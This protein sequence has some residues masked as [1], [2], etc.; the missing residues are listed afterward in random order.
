LSPTAH[1]D[2]I[3]DNVKYPNVYVGDEVTNVTLQKLAESQMEIYDQNKP[4][5]NRCLLIIDDS[6]SELKR[7][8]LR[9]MF[10]KFTTM[11]RHW[12]GDIIWACHNLTFMENSQIGN[13]L[14]WCIWD[15]HKKSLKTLSQSLSTAR[16][17]EPSLQ[18]FI[19]EN[20]RNPYSFVFIDYSKPPDK[21]FYIGFDEVYE[22][23]TESG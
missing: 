5:E 11:W 20:T 9:Y 22:P 19:R 8:Q 2:R 12:G 1:Y 3:W 17:D 13:A 21:T 18:K 6:S 4:K 14:Q 7:K 16:M 10:T 15:L 23:Q